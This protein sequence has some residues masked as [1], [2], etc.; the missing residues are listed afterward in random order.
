MKQAPDEFDEYFIWLCCLVNADLDLYSELMFY[1]HDTDFQWCLELDSSRAKEGLEL[2]EEF[3]EANRYYSDCDWVMLMDKPCSVLEALISIARRMDDMLIDDDTSER[4]AVWFWEMIKNLGLKRFTD[5]LLMR[6][7][8]DD[9]YDMEEIL[10]RWM[11][12]DFEPDGT[13][14]IFPLRE[15]SCDQRERTIVYQ[16]NDYI[17]EN[18]LED[19]DEFL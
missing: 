15:A 2:R 3:Y 18:Y 19:N 17:L 14:S 6:G 7:N 16:L 4:V 12:R 8:E 5:I 10:A 1:L 9:Y 13:G 11:N